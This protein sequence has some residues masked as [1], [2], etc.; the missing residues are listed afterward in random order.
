MPTLRPPSAALRRPARTVALLTGLLLLLG[1]LLATAQ[2]ASRPERAAAADS[3]CTLNT[4]ACWMDNNVAAIGQRPLNQLVMP[5]SH[6]SGT[7]NV[8]ED[9]SDAKTQNL[10]VGRHPQP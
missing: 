6:D 5:A 10:T 8:K 7:Y 1:G 4:Y 9:F 2:E 3:T